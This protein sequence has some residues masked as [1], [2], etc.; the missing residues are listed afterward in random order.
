MKIRYILSILSV[1]FL[2]AVSC[3]EAKKSPR[4]PV[5]GQV[6]VIF[7]NAPG[8]GV[9]KRFLGSLSVPQAGTL[10]Y[11]DPALCRI[12][13]IPRN[14]G[15]DTLVLAAPYGYAEVIHRNQVIE[16]IPYLL[17]AG[18]TVLFSYGDNLRP[19]IRSLVSDNNTWLY[20]L[21]WEDSR[22]VQP[23]GYSTA[24]V[25]T[26]SEYR[27]A[28]E[29]VNHPKNYPSE[30][31]TKVKNFYINLD[32]L[33]PVYEAYRCDM[34]R[35]INSLERCGGIPEAYAGYYRQYLHENDSFPAEVP[36][37]DSLMRYI[38]HYTRALDYPYRICPGWKKSPQQF[39]CIAADTLLSPTIRNII[40]S[41]LLL[42]IEGRG[43][44]QPYPTRV[45]QKYR[46][47]YREIA[48]DT[49]YPTKRI[50][51]ENL[52]WNGY[53]TDLVLE[54][55]DGGSYAYGDLL[56]RYK[57]KVIYVDIWA[58][59]CSACR[60]A[61]PDAKKLREHYKNREVVFL[62][63]AVNDTREAWRGAVQSCETGYLGENYRVLN[64]AESRFLKEV[65]NRGIPQMLLYDRSG[66]LVDTDTSGPGE[67]ATEEKIDKLLEMQ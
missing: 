3:R 47:R 43:Y 31:M 29:T 34:L 28:D 39:D 67:K 32:S 64:A 63:L 11:V 49:T 5:P 52:L 1:S 6:T 22:A 24:T 20:N 66:R 44:W 17:L 25:L 30:I 45:V 9:T 23:V 7:D 41:D 56:S 55:L 37:P 38:S 4:E 50:N 40:L 35:R 16:D 10:I 53:S 65:K 19:Q 60:D 36:G 62:Y 48:G 13:Y 59:W 57:G 42:Q 33:R 8:Q 27:W 51:K 2:M 46:E 26:S 54:G 61:M 14:I 15:Y 12:F 21:P 58:S 18:D